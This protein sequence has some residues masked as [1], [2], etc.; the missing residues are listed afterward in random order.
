[1]AGGWGLYQ[2]DTRR[3]SHMVINEDHSSQRFCQCTLGYDTVSFDLGNNDLSV[4][5]G[6]VGTVI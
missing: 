3:H 4:C 5:V 2:I 6:K 1:M